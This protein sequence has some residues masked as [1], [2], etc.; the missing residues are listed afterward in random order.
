MRSG[1]DDGCREDLPA[2]ASLGFI[3][4]TSLSI[5][6]P[7]RGAPEACENT[8]ASILQNRPHDCEVVVPHAGAYDDPYDLAGEVTFVAAPM[9]CSLIEQINLG[10]RASRG[11]TAHLVLPGLE[12]EEGWTAPALAHFADPAV[13]AVTP[14][15]VDAAAR[16]VVCG[17]VAHRL[18]GAR[19]IV[20][21][22]AR[23]LS[24]R[25][26]RTRYAAP[27]LLAGFWRRTAW[28]QAGGFDPAFGEALADLDLACALKAL[29]MTA[30]LE[31]ESRLVQQS[32]EA[33]SLPPWKEGR[34]TERLFWKHLSRPGCGKALSLHCLGLAV[35]LPGMVFRP[36]GW[37][38][39][40][41]RLF[42]IADLPACR[43]Y[44]RERRRNAVG[45]GLDT[46]TSSDTYRRRDAGTL[47]LERERRAPVQRKA[48]QPS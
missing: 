47:L 30:V 8:L 40:I 36:R 13:A 27:A 1:A 45:A 7:W 10:F 12:V 43:R 42:A 24:P 19:K 37:A 2:A 23:T 21:Q 9:G 14:L 15:V 33:P 5:I 35:E 18:S 20:L 3:L 46:A 4:V 22:G 41:G 17:G 16:R 39:M 6:V 28:E 25:L 32:G 38:K 34:L 44:W 29:G 48:I 31:T 26:R 11:E